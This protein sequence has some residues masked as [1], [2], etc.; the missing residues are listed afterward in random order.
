M[1]EIRSV[2][3]VP[4]PVAEACASLV[5]EEVYGLTDVSRHGIEGYMADVADNQNFYIES[6]NEVVSFGSLRLLSSPYA[7]IDT[8]VTRSDHQR[9]GL[10]R[11][12]LTHLENRATQA[13]YGY[14][15]IQSPRKTQHILVNLGFRVVDG[16][17]LMQ[18]RLC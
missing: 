14:V 3:M 1:T 17:P 10:G 5:Y 6:D 8:L 13:A 9:Q 15:Q 18:K 7:M 2:I 4:G 12:M 11:L 16:G